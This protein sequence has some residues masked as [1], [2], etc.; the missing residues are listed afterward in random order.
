MKRPPEGFKRLSSA[1]LRE[2]LR[3]HLAEERKVT[4]QFRVGPLDDDVGGDEL[5]RVQIKGVHECGDSSVPEEHWAMLRLDLFGQAF[6]RGD[7]GDRAR[8]LV[9]KRLYVSEWTGWTGFWHPTGSSVM[10]LRL[11]GQ[12]RLV[13]RVKIA[14]GA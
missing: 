8:L 10:L 14:A 12:G 9:H 13:A 7:E 3:N 4:L 1:E 11:S 5:A 2:C 6:E